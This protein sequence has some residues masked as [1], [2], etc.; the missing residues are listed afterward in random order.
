MFDAPQSPASGASDNVTNSTKGGRSGRRPEGAKDELRR[1][2]MELVATRERGDVAALRSVLA[3]YP[4]HAAALIDFDAGLVAT[5]AYADVTLTHAVEVIGAAAK[6]NA[7]AAVFGATTVAPAATSHAAAS[8][9][10]LRAAQKLSLKAVADRLG[11]GIDV[12]HALENGRIRAP[13]VPRRFLSALGGVLDTSAEQLAV[14][15]GG[16]AVVNP[17]FQRTKTGET[18]ESASAEAEPLD[19]A[20]MIRLST[21]MTD[22]QKAAWLDEDA[23]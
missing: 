9:K 12:V 3:H 11:L 15:L 17:L 14:V 16:Q 19:F 6:R 20:D 10:E 5:A 21:S 8:L 7:F 1:A 22:A 13:S 2:Q 23:R 18:K 4:Q